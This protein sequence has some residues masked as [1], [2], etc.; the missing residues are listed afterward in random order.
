MLKKLVMASFKLGLAGAALAAG[1]A[2]GFGFA[3]NLSEE[4]RRRIKKGFFELK[5]LPRRV[6]V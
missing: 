2:I 6:L 3:L 1:L 4:D 5:E